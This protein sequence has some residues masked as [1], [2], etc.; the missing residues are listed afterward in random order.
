MAADKTRWKSFGSRTL[1]AYITHWTSSILRIVDI[2]HVD[3][4]SFLKRV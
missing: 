4:N 1:G 2:R 3:V